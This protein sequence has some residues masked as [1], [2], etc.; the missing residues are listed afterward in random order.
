[1]KRVLWVVAILT[2]N[3]LLASAFEGPVATFV[4]SHDGL[5]IDTDLR[6]PE[7][8]VPEGGWP[9]IVL[10]HGRR[11]SKDN[12]R[13]PAEYYADR[14]YVT[15]AYS[16]RGDGESTEGGDPNDVGTFARG[17]DVGALVEWLVSDPIEGVKVNSERVGMTGR[18][19]GGINSWY[20]VIYNDMLACAAPQNFSMHTWDRGFVN[21]GSITYRL[22][23][24][25]R[26][27][28]LLENYD[29]DK[30][31]SLMKMQRVTPAVGKVTEPIYLAHAMLDAWTPA[32]NTLLDFEAAA[33]SK[34]KILYIGTGGHGT[35]DSDQEYVDEYLRDAWFDHFLKGEDNGVTKL[36]QYHF[37]LLD[38]LEKV[39]CDEFPH[40]NE[41][42]V[43][44]HFTSGNR[45]SRTPGL[46]GVG[47][48]LSE[49]GMTMA[50]L[51]AA[52][53][54]EAALIEGFAQSSVYV[55]TE[56]MEEDVVLLGIPMVEFRTCVKDSLKYQVNVHLYDVAPDGKA[57]FLSWAT[58]TELG[59]GRSARQQLDMSVTGRRVEVGHRLRLEFT[60]LD[61]QE[62]E[63]GEDPIVRHM[64]I[65]EPSYVPI[66][67]GFISLPVIEG[68]LP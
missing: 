28:E 54:D 17:K 38:T 18:S 64:P 67:S 12:L 8:E 29:A 40:P 66:T 25:G 46:G 20:G 5:R 45:L 21:N 68:E 10:A 4:E 15:L 61:A 63:P 47:A 3:I 6:W 19:Q 1:M 23:R 49:P 60:N 44:Y 52:E 43:T 37:A 62:I 16:A 55:E 26:F 31:H 39:T 53:F 2:L 51:V 57:R 14:G 50:D 58:L 42:R 22:S 65:F 36:P 34:K 24:L 59:A 9:A 35:P 13:R 41:K 27:Q 56:P 32:N 7:G 11:G 33:S 48:Y 30:L